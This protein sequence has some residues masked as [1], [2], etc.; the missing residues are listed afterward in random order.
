M[1]EQLDMHT[2][3]PKGKNVRA[4][5]VTKE[6]LDAIAEW[7]PVVSLWMKSDSQESDAQYLWWKV[8]LGDYTGPD[9]RREGVDGSGT[10]ERISNPAGPTLTVVVQVGAGD[11]N[12]VTS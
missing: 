7:C 6:N 1:S 3:E 11:L 4:I 8:G 2:Y 9:G 5:Q 12:V 10:Y